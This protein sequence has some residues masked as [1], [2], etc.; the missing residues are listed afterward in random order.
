MNKFCD[1]IKHYDLLIDENNDPVFDPPRLKEY[2]DL[3]DGETFIKLLRVSNHDEVLEVG[4]GTGRLALRIAKYCKSFTGIDIS[5]KTI[6]RA[7]ENLLEFTNVHLI[8]EDFTK[9]VFVE[10][11]SLIYSSLTFMHFSDKISVVRKI[12]D[13]L[14]FNGRFVLSIDKN[15]AKIIDC[16]NRKLRIYPD[17]KNETE[18]ILRKCGFNV[19]KITETKNAV[20]FLSTKD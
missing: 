8:C 19:I 14:L 6:T 3:F 5:A 10:K 7:R 17:D 4:V 9:F 11:F 16:G 20:L 2:M 13:L 12:Y 18:H 1:V 15:P